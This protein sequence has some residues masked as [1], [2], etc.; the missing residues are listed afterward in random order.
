M[1]ATA[2]FVHVKKE[3]IDEFIDATIK[4]HEGSVQEPGNLR[5]D[6]LQSRS[7]PSCFMLYE[8]YASDEA[9]KA[10]KE[11]GHYKAWREAVESWMAR[12]RE[13]V[14]HDIIRPRDRAQW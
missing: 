11:T 2:V 9:A 3:H 7:D 12:P 1:I 5:F 14:A 10:H 6:V 4:N 8:V 13:G